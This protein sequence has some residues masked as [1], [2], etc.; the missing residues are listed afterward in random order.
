MMTDD[1]K[2]W[3]EQANTLLNAF[4]EM[5]KNNEKFTFGGAVEG[6]RIINMGLNIDKFDKL[7][8]AESQEKWQ[9]IK[10]LFSLLVEPAYYVSGNQSSSVN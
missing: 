5:V 6:A 1:Q 8:T 3:M 2:E 9:E 10:N 7:W 4:K